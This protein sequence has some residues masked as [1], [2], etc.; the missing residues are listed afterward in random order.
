MRRRLRRG[1]PEDR[2][3]PHRPEASTPPD[4]PP[5]PPRSVWFRPL[6]RDLTPLEL[7]AVAV[8]LA[9]ALI[10]RT[11]DLGGLPAGVHGDE[12]VVGAEAQRILDEGS[13]G[14]YSRHAGGQP[15]GPL[16]IS[17]LAMVVLS[18]TIETLR[19]VSALA[20]V[21]T[22]LALWLVARRNLGP[23]TALAAAALLAVLPWHVHFSRIAY[24]LIFWP[25]LAVLLAGALAEALR[26]GAW[27]WW[28]VTGLLLGGGVYV[29]NAHPLLVA[30]TGVTV[31]VSLL[32]TGRGRLG[33]L[34][35]QAGGLLVCAL[36]AVLVVLPM[37]RYAAGDGT[38]YGKHFDDVSTFEQEEWRALDERPEQARFIADTY[39]GYWSGLCCEMKLDVVDGTGLTPVVPVA[40]LLLAAAGVGL[41]LRTR[42]TPLIRFALVAILAMPA[43]AFL[44]EGGL[45][46]RTF[47]LA[48]VLALFGALAL[49]QLYGFL[50]RLVQWQ[51]TSVAHRR[52][53]PE[54]TPR[55]IPTHNRGFRRDDGA[56]AR[57]A[58][59]V[60]LAGALLVVGLLGYQSVG[61]YFNE[62]ADPEVQQRV[63]A[64][65][66]TDASRFMAELPDD[67]YVYFYSNRWSFNYITRR[68]LAPETRGEDRSKQFG[69]YHFWVQPAK[70]RPV[71][72]LLGHY[73][74]DFETVRERFPDGVVLWGG[75]D[76]SAT[77]IAYRVDG[78]QTG[79]SPGVRLIA[80]Q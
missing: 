5:D 80:E 19:L 29:Y 46:R 75:P 18:P 3:T 52:M 50:D 62:F 10:L 34:R 9:V 11:V 28:A 40:F 25:L 26:G 65:P 20:G 2:T 76:E 14:P 59:P 63:L 57:W 79:T 61:V 22:V 30:V 66:M 55:L 73:M 54:G 4:A 17:A 27:R 67:S 35:E 32:A 7:L 68:F 48:P 60:A 71:I 45:A 1:R 51:R 38:R 49:V 6:F 24:P 69:R 47:V 15:T 16:Y 58:R 74:N 36:C 44:T 39:V 64:V 13:I 72:V 41:A 12:A 42:R 31:L 53:D 33:A 21:L 23:G 70:G 37:A 78:F 77:F 56:D 8:V 43:A